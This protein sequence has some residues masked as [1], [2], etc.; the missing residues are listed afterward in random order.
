[1]SWTS[2]F[3]PL[4]LWQVRSVSHVRTCTAHW[5]STILNLPRDSRHAIKCQ[6]AITLCLDEGG[7]GPCTSRV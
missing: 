5:M 3:E 1:M 6:Q 2:E 7:T 4:Q